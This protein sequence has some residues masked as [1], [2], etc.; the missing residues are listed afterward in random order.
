[1][2][3]RGGFLKRERE[4]KNADGGRTLSEAILVRCGKLAG[5]SGFAGGRH[6]WIEKVLSSEL[7]DRAEIWKMA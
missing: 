2:G 6:G 3:L 4:Q 7:I 1:M 5:E